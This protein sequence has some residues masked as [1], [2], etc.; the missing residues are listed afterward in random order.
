[1]IVLCF[2]VLIALILNFENNSYLSNIPYMVIL[3]EGISVIIIG[4]L[5][6]RNVLGK[7]NDKAIQN[8]FLL[9]LII[10]FYFFSLYTFYMDSIYER[11]LWY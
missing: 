9:F 3:L 5:L 6:I 1:M 8:T 4:W 2:L 10:L 11:K 7:A